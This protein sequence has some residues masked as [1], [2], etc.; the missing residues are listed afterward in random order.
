VKTKK[1]RCTADLENNIIFKVMARKGAEAQRF[2][3]LWWINPPKRKTKIC[4]FFPLQS[5]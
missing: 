5:A 4:V 1:I 2:S 3:P